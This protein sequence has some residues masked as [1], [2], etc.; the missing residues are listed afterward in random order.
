MLEEERNRSKS[1]QSEITL[2]R[3]EIDGLMSELADLSRQQNETTCGVPKATCP[4]SNFLNG[5]S[6][7]MVGG[8]DSLETH[9]KNLI[10][11]MGGKFHRHDGY[12]RN[13]EDGLEDV[14]GKANL[15]VCPIE[16]N[17]HNAARSAKRICKARGIP[18]CFVKSASL[19]TLK[20][21]I[22]NVAQEAAA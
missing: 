10:E 1:F 13:G 16:V 9:Y 12:C 14:I 11:S 15:V 6:V 22:E 4:I 8:L 7:A 3:N 21:T 17:S 20:R 5:M 2:F 18:C 19:A